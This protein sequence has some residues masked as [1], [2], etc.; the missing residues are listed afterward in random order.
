[1][2]GMRFWF[3]DALVCLPLILMALVAWMLYVKALPKLEAMESERIAAKYKSIA[4]EIKDGEAKSPHEYAMGNRKSTG[5]LSR[6]TWGMERHDGE[7]LV[8]YRQPKATKIRGVVVPEERAFDYR[9]YFF[10]IVGMGLMVALLIANAGLRYFRRFAKE[11]EDFLFAVMHDLTTPLVGLRMVIGKDDE[12]ARNLTERMLRM[13]GN[14]RDFMAHD[15]HRPK[16]KPENVDLRKTCDEAYALF[17]ADYE[18]SKFGGVE[19][20]GEGAAFADPQMTVQILWNL[21][22]NDLKYAIPYGK[23]SVRIFRD[24]KFSVI[25]FVDEGHGMTRWQ[26]RHAFDRYYRAKTVQETGRGGFG[27]G[28]CNSRELAMAMGGRLTVRANNPTGCIFA[29]SLPSAI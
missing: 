4:V 6:G 19:I 17:R 11:R 16:P 23:V 9:R 12:E 18:D 24:G 28:L 15:G 2:R 20:V 10:A 22:G 3:G 13:V 27:I 21:F 1:M 14:I 29:L 5:K 7:M 25:E 8:W 26:M